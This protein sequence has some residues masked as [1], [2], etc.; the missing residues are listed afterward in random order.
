[1]FEDEGIPRTKDSMDLFASIAN[2]AIFESKQIFLVL[3]K[4]DIFKKKLQANPDKFQTAYPGFSGNIGNPDE[5]IAWV[6]QSFVSKLNPDRSSDAWVEGL[7]CCA[8]EDASIRELFQKI[9]RKVL[10]GR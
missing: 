2:S 8:M 5:A 3:N 9:G 4:V 6:K 7:T 10:D 1:M